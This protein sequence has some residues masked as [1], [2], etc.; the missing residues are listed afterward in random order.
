MKEEPNRSWDDFEPSGQFAGTVAVGF[1]GGAIG[2]GDFHGPTLPVDHPP[3]TD[4]AASK[5]SVG[6]SEKVGPGA[7]GIHAYIEEPVVQLSLA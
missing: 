6:M 5:G 2:G 3:L 7:T 4:V 1:D